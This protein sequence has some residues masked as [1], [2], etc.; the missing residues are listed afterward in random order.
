MGISFLWVESTAYA[1]SLWV[2]CL[3]LTGRK[4]ELG[5]REPHRGGGCGGS[6]RQTL[7]NFSKELWV[8]HLL[9]E[10]VGGFGEE[11]DRY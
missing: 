5:S 2:A 6:R 3:S 1:K 7:S 4:Q 11:E 10:F 8:Y 9:G